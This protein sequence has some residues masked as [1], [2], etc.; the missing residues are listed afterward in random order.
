[1]STPLRGKLG[2]LRGPTLAQESTG[3]VDHEMWTD[4]EFLIKQSTALTDFGHSSS[5]FS[6]T[7]TNSSGRWSSAGQVL[8]ANAKDYFALAHI[9]VTA[10]AANAMNRRAR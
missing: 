9:F 6:F 4:L 7:L 10:S 2:R 8:K 1:M 5:T 3:V